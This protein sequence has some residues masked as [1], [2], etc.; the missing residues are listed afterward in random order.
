MNRTP[1]TC[2]QPT[3]LVDLDLA[4]ET[5]AALEAIAAK[6]GVSVEQVIWTALDQGILREFGS[7]N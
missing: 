1:K 7:S 5:W 4:P 2:Y 3:C 6:K